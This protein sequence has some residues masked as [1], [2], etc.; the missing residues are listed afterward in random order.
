MRT[1]LIG[2][3]NTFDLGQIALAAVVFAMAF[4]LSCDRAKSLTETAATRNVTDDLGRT[5]NVPLK[6][7]RAVS[8]APSLTE[9][10]FAVGAGDTLVGV[11]SY[12]N[13]PEQAK[14]VQ[15]IG[16]TMTPNIER[17]IALKPQVVFVSTS[18]Q[19]EAFTK[20]LDEQGIAVFVSDAKSLDDVY[21]SFDQFGDLFGTKKQAS[22][23]ISGLKRR[24]EAV[25]TRVDGKA[26]PPKVFVQISNDP[27]F[28]I[29]KNS[30]LTEILEQAGGTSATK[31]VA[32]A[33]PKLSKE[34]ALALN[35]DVIILSDSDD[36]K[37]PNEVF[38][39][40]PAV[41][42]GRIYRINADIISRPGPRL[43]DAI[44]QIAT[45]LYP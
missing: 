37:E 42:N 1:F 33:Y 41:K 22:N 3:S 29:G 13:Y 21:R 2:R 43:V 16:D 14:S 5:V 36:N 15:K 4:L 12:C 20:T 8:L 39:N 19:L 10:I 31:D 26:N 24:A 32:T 7:D 40:S 27:L 45:D 38:K 28:T 35:P 9:M 11:T 25:R 44:E 18:S 6:I 17:I 30:F 34:T 23:I